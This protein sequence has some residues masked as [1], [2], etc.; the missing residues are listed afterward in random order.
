MKNNRP[1]GLEWFESLREN[2]PLWRD[3]TQWISEMVN[4]ELKKTTGEATVE[5]A[6][7]LIG[8]V[9]G[10]KTV[11]ILL[12]EERNVESSYGQGQITLA[13]CAEQYY[14]LL[15]ESELCTERYDVFTRRLAP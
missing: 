8:R 6:V 2:R 7:E 10:V 15:T 1:N 3:M 11:V 9:I 13:R 12:S 4:S 14:S 5:A